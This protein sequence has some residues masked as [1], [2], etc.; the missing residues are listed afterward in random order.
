[1]EA[2]A[3]PTPT[4]RMKGQ[5]PNL[6]PTQQEDVAQSTQSLHSQSA[7]VL[8]VIAAHTDKSD[9]ITTVGANSDH[10]DKEAADDRTSVAIAFKNR[11][12]ECMATEDV[13]A[14]RLLLEDLR[15]WQPCT[16]SLRR[17]GPP[18]IF[19]DVKVWEDAKVYEEVI[20]LRSRFC[21]IMKN[22][23]KNISADLTSPFK[24][25]SSLQFRQSVDSME[26]FIQGGHTFE[27]EPGLD[28]KLAYHLVMNKFTVPQALE[29]L[30]ADACSS[31]AKSFHEIAALNRAIDNGAAAAAFNRHRML[32]ARTDEFSSAIN[33]AK[34]VDAWEVTRLW[35]KQYLHAAGLK[36][37]K[38]SWNWASISKRCAQAT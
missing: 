21:R 3:R 8:S 26:A 2:F 17:S 25:V 5:S 31:F 24:D 27:T 23:R 34:M 1:M 28:R 37:Q 13:N 6:P 9:N 20:E 16:T 14:I 38:T 29:G 32:M 12:V 30:K 7:S 33:S 19:R 15:G 11:A 18:L 4:G 10:A 35:N 36:L 22:G